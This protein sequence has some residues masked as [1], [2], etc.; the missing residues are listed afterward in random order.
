MDDQK[1][2]D[3]NRAHRHGPHSNFYDPNNPVFDKNHTEE[4]VK[5]ILLAFFIMTGIIFLVWFFLL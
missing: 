4:R 1:R 3:L 5:Q 2:M